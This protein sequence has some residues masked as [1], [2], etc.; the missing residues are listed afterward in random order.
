MASAERGEPT[1]S[2]VMTEAEAAAVLSVLACVSGGT[3]NTRR[4]LTQAVSVALE[5]AGVTWD[6]GD[7]CGATG[8]EL[9][10]TDSRAA[11]AL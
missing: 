1:V 6:T 7:I 3:K 10:F 4:G 11:D 5:G 8:K 2:L 9:R